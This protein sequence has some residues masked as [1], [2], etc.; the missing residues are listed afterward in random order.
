MRPELRLV[1]TLLSSMSSE[2]E[3]PVLDPAFVWTLELYHDDEPL[4]RGT[5][6]LV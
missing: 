2:L 1:L 4:V 6:L 3:D 5:V